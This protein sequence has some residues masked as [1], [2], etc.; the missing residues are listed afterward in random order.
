MNIDS[1]REIIKEEEEDLVK[2]N[3]VEE[4]DIFF[5]FEILINN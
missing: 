5:I 4:H 1:V 2:R 3:H